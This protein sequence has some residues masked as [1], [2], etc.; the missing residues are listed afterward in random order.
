[1]TAARRRRKEKRAL[2][3][4]FALALAA[5]A[6]LVPHATAGAITETI[7][8]DRHTGLAIG[9][10]DPVA[11]YTDGKPLSGSP[12]FELHYGGA[13]WRFCNIGNR[14]AFAERPDVYM[15]RFGGYDPVGV[16]RGVAVAGRP[17]VWLISG[18]QLFLFHSSQRLETFA[19][20]PEHISG[21]AERKWPAVLK[22]L[23][24]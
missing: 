3:A 5:F 14:A 12:D 4:V 23:S 21:V 17:D 1:M 24:P 11:F 22:T 13:V 16:A 9:G 6:G 7:V 20:N 19:A 8:V 2:I 18:G 10:Y 15:P